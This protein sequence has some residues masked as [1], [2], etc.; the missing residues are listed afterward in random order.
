MALGAEND[1]LRKENY[2]FRES[3]KYLAKRESRAGD[4]M[5]EWGPL[6][7]RAALNVIADPAKLD[8]FTVDANKL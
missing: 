3:M 8:K 7:A 1:R 4:W 6:V 2:I 5:A